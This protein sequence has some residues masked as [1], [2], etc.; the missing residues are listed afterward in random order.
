M[1]AMVGVSTAVEIAAYQGRPVPSLADGTVG[2][3]GGCAAHAGWEL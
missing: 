3:P 1:V 2:A